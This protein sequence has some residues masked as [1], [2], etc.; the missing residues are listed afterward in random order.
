MQDAAETLAAFMAWLDERAADKAQRLRAADGLSDARQR[1]RVEI[2]ELDAIRE[3]LA[4]FVANS[5]EPD[6]IARF[7][8]RHRSTLQGLA[9]R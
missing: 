6:A 5:E 7:I 1:L 4:G 3:A 2:G 8:D 9:D